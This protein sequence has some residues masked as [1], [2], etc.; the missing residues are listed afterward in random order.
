MQDTD[1]YKLTLKEYKSLFDKLYTSLCIFA[2]KYIENI[3]ISKDIVQDVFIRIW[4]KKVEFQDENNIKSYIYTAVKNKSLDYL[5]SKRYKSTDNYA[6]ADIEKLEAEAY[7]LREVVIE[8]T[9]SI[10]EDAINTLPNKCAQIIRL[11][12]KNFTNPQIAEELGIS[13]NTVKAQKRIAYQRLRPIL[14]DYFILIAFI[15]D[16]N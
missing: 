9:S 11:S 7:F 12:I 2:N 14:K 16:N 4:E 10:I 6:S 8:E 5:K 3:E 15:F 1:K 13:I